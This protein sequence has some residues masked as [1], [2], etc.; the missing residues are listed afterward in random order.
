MWLSCGENGSKMTKPSY[1]E[2]FF[3][4][5]ESSVMYVCTYC[6]Y[7]DNICECDD[8]IDSKEHILLKITTTTELVQVKD[9]KQE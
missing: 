6:Y 3:S 2:S 7:A 1:P 5:R 8:Q 4:T 9:I